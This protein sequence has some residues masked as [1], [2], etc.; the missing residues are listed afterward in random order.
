MKNQIKINKEFLVDFE[1]YEKDGIKMIM[2]NVPGYGGK[3][4]HLGD[5]NEETLAR[6]LANELITGKVD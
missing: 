2:V 4:T 3:T 6:I 1:V 5:S